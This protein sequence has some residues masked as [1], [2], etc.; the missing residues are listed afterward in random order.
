MNQITNRF[1]FKQCRHEGLF[2][3]RRFSER[4]SQALRR[5]ASDRSMVQ[6]ASQA[7]AGAVCEVPEEVANT[8]ITRNTL[9][10]ASHYV[11]SLSLTFGEYD[12]HG[13]CYSLII[14]V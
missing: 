14:M 10:T 3:M 6:R 13:L 1:I 2:S 5:K 8:T 11:K 9:E 12:F 7:K 4:M